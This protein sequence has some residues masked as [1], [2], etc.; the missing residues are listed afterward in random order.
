M[1]KITRIS[2][3]KV[4]IYVR[5][6]PSFSTIPGLITGA[7]LKFLAWTDYLLCLFEMCHFSLVCFSCN[8]FETCCYDCCL[9]RC[10]VLNLLHQCTKYGAP[11]V[12]CSTLSSKSKLVHAVL[13]RIRLQHCVGVRYILGE[14]LLQRGDIPLKHIQV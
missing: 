1:S 6:F 3:P 13:W 12:L 7:C 14:L 8:F 5:F 4:G 11:N 10:L 9:Q 2:S